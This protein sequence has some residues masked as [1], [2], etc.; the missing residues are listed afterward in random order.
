MLVPCDFNALE[1][2]HKIESLRASPK[3]DNVRLIVLNVDASQRHLNP[4]EKFVQTE[5]HLHNYLKNFNH[6]IYY[7][8]DKNVIE[9]ILNFKKLN[10]VELMIALPGQYS[11]LYS[12]T[13]KSVSQGLYR[14]TKIP[15]MI[16]K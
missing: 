13:H 2:L 12:I 15:V 9:G 8:A 16:L 3:W 7:V 4:D 6:Q 10:E 5:N 1:H 14:N 11:F